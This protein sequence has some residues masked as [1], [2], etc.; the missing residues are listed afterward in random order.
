LFGKGASVTRKF[1]LKP[2]YKLK[3]KFMYAK[4]DS[5]DAEKFFLKVDGV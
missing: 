5:W 1:E 2:H 3:V 4:I